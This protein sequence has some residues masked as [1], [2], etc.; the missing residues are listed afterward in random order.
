[1]VFLKIVPNLF[2]VFSITCVILLLILFWG[3]C[4]VITMNNK[5]I[6]S[7]TSCLLAFRCAYYYL[8]MSMFNNV[9]RCMHM[10]HNGLQVDY[11]VHKCNLSLVCSR[12]SSSCILKH[13]TIV[14]SAPMCYAN[15]HDVNKLHCKRL[16]M[17][18]NDI[19]LSMSGCDTFRTSCV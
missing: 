3:V 14:W 6:I 11:S 4:Y 2:M 7:V 19:I 8:G 15:C 17:L 18:T 13:K 5:F 9:M 16:L 10:L 1:M 12:M